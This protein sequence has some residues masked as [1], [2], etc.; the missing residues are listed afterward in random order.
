[1]EFASAKCICSNIQ[2]KDIVNRLPPFKNLYD[3]QI[4]SQQGNDNRK[5][6]HDITYLQRFLRTNR[7]IF[8][9]VNRL[10]KFRL[11]IRFRD[12]VI[13]VV[14][15]LYSETLIIRLKAALCIVYLCGA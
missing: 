3:L 5:I 9:R 12:H 7:L 14:L 4:V 15:S 1:M 6:K 2:L 11:K 13:N 8:L 10:F